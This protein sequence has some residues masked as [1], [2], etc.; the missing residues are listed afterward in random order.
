MLKISIKLETAEHPLVK[1]QLDA[2]RQ[3]I[4]L[5]EKQQEEHTTAPKQKKQRSSQPSAE[6]ITSILNMATPSIIAFSER[7]A[8][9]I[10]HGSHHSPSQSNP[11]QQESSSHSAAAAAVA[12]ETGEEESHEED[13]PFTPATSA[14]TP[15]PASSSTPASSTS[16]APPTPFSVLNDT[17]NTMSQLGVDPKFANM[18]E[19]FGDMLL[20]MSSQ[21]P[22]QQ[23]GQQTSQPEK[24]SDCIEL[25]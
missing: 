13:L 8:S 9:K 12:A 21:Q 24:N 16:V 23:P 15:T 18:I 7:I 4:V 25:D 14:T 6:S 17:R 22:K 1:N 20:C 2:L 19:N 10:A 3:A 11:A 5:V